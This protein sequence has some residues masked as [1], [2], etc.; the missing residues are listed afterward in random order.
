LGSVSSVFALLVLF[1]GC[2]NYGDGERCNSKGINSGSDDCQAGL[3]C[4]TGAQRSDPTGPDLCCPADRTT[5]TSVLCRGAKAISLPDAAIL[6]TGVVDSATA[7]DVV[8][9]GGMSTEGG[10]SDASGEGG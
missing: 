7:P 6:D 8:T 5:S 4:T 1:G 2:T 9:D 3:A 10:L